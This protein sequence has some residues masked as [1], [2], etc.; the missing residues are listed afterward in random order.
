MANAGAAQ[1]QGDGGLTPQ[2]AI[3]WE[4]FVKAHA[5]LAR[6]LDADLR[7]AHGLPLC[8][9]EIL[10]LLNREACQP[11]RMAALA[12]SAL[13]SPSGLS[14][15]VERLEARSLVRRDRC[16]NDRRGTLALLTESGAALVEAASATHASAIRRRFLQR[17]TPAQL[18]ALTEG[19]HLVLAEE[20]G[21]CS[22]W[23]GPRPDDPSF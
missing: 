21:S 23:L 13:L 9:F 4:R 18:I 15:A 19:F 1:P 6:G 22:T 14:R 5:A 2:E 3:T 8:D 17:L 20:T 7:A 16:P 11:V 10:S 12:D